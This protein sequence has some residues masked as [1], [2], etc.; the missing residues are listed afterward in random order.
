MTP[1]GHDQS[2]Q[3]NFKI[4]KG[5]NMESINA[6]KSA[7]GLTDMVLNS[8]IGD[9]DDAELMQRPGKGCNHIAWQLGHL[10]SSEANLLNMIKDG[11]AIDLPEGF[12]D[13]HSKETTGSDDA[14]QFC[15]KQEYVDLYQKTRENTVATLG[16][17]TQEEMAAPAPEHFQAF[18]P[19]MGDLAMMIASH[20]MMHV[21]QFVPVRRALDKPIV[22]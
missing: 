20:P 13:K 19:T 8:Y 11:S 6:I 2:A 9:L 15:S 1:K 14:A 4:S 22:I 7:F 10:I 18:C 16:S 5:N 21:G 3:Q 17:L 12:A